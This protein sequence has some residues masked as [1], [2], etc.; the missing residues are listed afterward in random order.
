M[1]YGRFDWLGALAAALGYCDLSGCKYQSNLTLIWASIGFLIGSL[2]LW[3]EA[4]DKYPVEKE[5]HKS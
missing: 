5:G 3:F 4:L 1:E 2:I